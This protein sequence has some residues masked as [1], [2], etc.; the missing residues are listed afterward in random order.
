MFQGVF[1]A[2]V[3]PFLNG[4]I[5]FESLEKLIDFQLQGGIQGFVVCGTTGESATL[6]LEEQMSV[7][8]F[9]CKK[10]GGKVPL[11]FGSGTNST[12]KTIELSRKA[13]EYPIDGLLVV[14]P[15]YNKP[16]QEGLLAH[17]KAVADAA[18]KP[19]VLYNVPGRTVAALEPSTVIE[20]SKHPN[21]CGIKEANGNL[22]NFAKYK[23]HTPK[24]FSLLSGDDESCVA[25]CLMGGHGVISVCSHISPSSMVGWIKR[26][27]SG[28]ETVKQEFAQQCEWIQ[29]LYLTSNPIPVKA[30][31]YKLGI[32]RT[33]EM[34]LPMTPMN[35]DLENTMMSSL[36]SFRDFLK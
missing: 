19:V 23:D 22:D 7:L 15:Y 9:V 28:D 21:I 4:K 17:F 20:L 3:T 16:N 27:R 32:I 13:C 31:L 30:A 8:D 35:L 2:L 36:D 26:A 14:V 12:A 24:D 34:R 18:K 6:N 5:D 1:T 10:V 11:L 25:F 33:K 29:K